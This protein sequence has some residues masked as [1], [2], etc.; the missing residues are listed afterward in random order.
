[1]ALRKPLVIA[2]DQV[3]Q[4]QAGDTLDAPQ[5]GGDQQVLTND[6]ATPVVIGAPVYVDA[7]DG[8][9]KAQANA[10]GTASVIGLAAK[11]PSIA[12]AAAGPVTIS[13]VLTA[14]AAQWDAVTG[15]VGGLVFNKKYFLSALT[16][17]KITQTAPIVVGNLVVEVGVALSTT[18]LKVNIQRTI[19]L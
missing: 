17:G 19:L 6:E 3:E 12:A 16:A 4:L 7:N 13:G 1:M 11:D 9:K 15:D 5:G 2:G 8:F 10:V 14:T 18:E